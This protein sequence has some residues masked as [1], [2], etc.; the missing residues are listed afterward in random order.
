[1]IVPLPNS[2][3]SRAVSTSP[4]VVSGGGDERPTM[5]MAGLSAAGQPSTTCTASLS[6]TMP[7]LALVASVT[8]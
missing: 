4:S 8:R 6:T 7:T 2:D 5:N 1:L 3:H